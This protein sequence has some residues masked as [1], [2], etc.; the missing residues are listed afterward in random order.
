MRY[1]AALAYNGTRFHGWQRQP[2]HIT[3][4]QHLEEKLSTM[5]RTPI[6][7]TGC[8]RTDTGVH[9]SFYVMH[10]D[11]NGEFPDQFLDK[12]N[13]FIG[14]DVAIFSVKPV[15]QNAHAR[16]DAEWRSY[17]YYVNLKKNPFT[18]ETAYYIS[19]IKNLDLDKMNELVALL[20]GYTDF[21]P[22]CK[23]GSDEKTKKCT[24]IHTSWEHRPDTG[25]L[26]FSITANRF[27]RSMV[28]LIVGESLNVGFGRTTID[29]FVYAMDNQL[30]LK[31][32]WTAPPQGLFL[33]DVQYKGDKG[34]AYD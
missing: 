28:R 16:F 17:K 34:E 14:P 9:A 32:A 7:V 33:T 27:L 4:Q 12:I 24:V 21:E 26:I 31:K 1:F 2:A 30:P 11:Y 29:D 15:A 10:F 13:N 22:L 19:F 5:L 3:V 6:F 18:Q 23:K 8:G 25:E 20:P